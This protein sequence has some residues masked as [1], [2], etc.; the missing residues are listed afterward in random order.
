[1]KQLKY[2]FEFNEILLTDTILEKLGFSDWWGGSGD[3]SDSRITLG[4]QLFEIHSVDEKDD[5]ADGY[6]YHPKQY[7]AYHY[8]SGDWNENIYFLHDLYEYIKDF[9]NK[10]VLKEFV[11]RCVKT[12]LKPNID[13]YL[14]Y[15]ENETNIRD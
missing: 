5:D 15:I 3:F 11:E 13:S 1:M 14:K 10:E 4:G 7:V 9:D 6:G 8:I 12:N 2:P